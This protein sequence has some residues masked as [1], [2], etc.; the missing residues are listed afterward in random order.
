MKKVRLTKEDIANTSDVF[1]EALNQMNIE[2]LQDIIYRE[3]L[4]ISDIIELSRFYNYDDYEVSIR[5]NTEEQ[6]LLS[7]IT[8]LDAMW[9]DSISVLYNDIVLNPNDMVYANRP[10]VQTEEIETML[11][12]IETELENINDLSINPNINIDM[13]INELEFKDMIDTELLKQKIEEGINEILNI[14]NSQ[15]MNY[16][17]NDLIELMSECEYY[18]IRHL[19]TECEQK[20]YVEVYI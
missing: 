2:D 6:I 12:E 4:K 19:T 17:E 14:L 15:V 8:D 16:F 10:T 7:L 13:Y 3:N 9:Y 11:Y 20:G 5:F 1:L 18:N